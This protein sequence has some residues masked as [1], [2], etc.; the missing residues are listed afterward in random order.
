MLPD[1]ELT[2]RIIGA[3]IEVHK[4]LGPGFLESAYEEAL[5][6][7]F[8]HQGIV[9]ERQKV[10]PVFYR[11]QKIA[12]HRLDFLVESCVVVELKAISALEDIHFAIVRSYLKA[13]H[14]QSALLLNFTTMPLTVKR[15]GREEAARQ[16]P[17]PNLLPS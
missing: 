16:K 7:E 14:L 17:S 2:Q 3:A 13:A 4:A 10:L 1:Q 15:V 6:I 11:D 12:E 9:F 5:A 8:R